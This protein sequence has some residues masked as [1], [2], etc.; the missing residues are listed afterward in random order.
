MHGRKPEPLVLND[1]D[2]KTLQ[3]LLRK[4]Q[5]PVRIARC[6]QIL[7]SYAEARRHAVW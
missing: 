3:K 5:M 4:G 2:S 6:A 7:L 1:K